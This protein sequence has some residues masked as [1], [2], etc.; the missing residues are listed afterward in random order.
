MVLWNTGAKMD[1]DKIETYNKSKGLTIM[2]QGGI[3]GAVG[4]TEL[5]V[6]TRDEDA[7]SRAYSAISYVDTLEQ[8]LLPIYNGECFM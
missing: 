6:M 2:V 4:R 1:A 3:G 8:G 5:I 7:F